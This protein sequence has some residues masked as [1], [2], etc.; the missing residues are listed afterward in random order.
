MKITVLC[1]ICGLPKD[2]CKC[3]VTDAGKIL[4]ELVI[5]DPCTNCGS[6]L[7]NHQDHEVLKCLKELG[8]KYHELQGMVL[9]NLNNSWVLKSK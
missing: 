2:I 9:N 7:G 6:S 1:T 5:D 8:A 4:N 3:N